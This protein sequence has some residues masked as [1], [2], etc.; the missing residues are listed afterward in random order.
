LETASFCAGFVQG[1]G[2]THQYSTLTFLIEPC[3]RPGDMILAN[4]C[5]YRVV[6]FE[7]LTL[8]VR[9]VGWLELTVHTLMHP[10][11]YA[12]GTLCVARYKLWQMITR[13][14]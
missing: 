6:K 7:G 8:E 11:L 3:E 14:H 1:A 12:Y 4:N 9:T 13:Q 10:L 2:M 5:V